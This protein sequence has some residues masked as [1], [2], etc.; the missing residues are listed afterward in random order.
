MYTKILPVVSHLVFPH[1]DP[2]YYNPEHIWQQRT[3]E[4]LRDITDLHQSIN[5]EWWMDGGTSEG[6]CVGWWGVRSGDKRG[7][8]YD[9]RDNQG[10]GMKG[11]R[12]DGG[13][14][15]REPQV[16]LRSLVVQSRAHMT[17]TNKRNPMLNHW[18]SSV[19]QLGMVDGWGGGQRG[20]VSSGGGVW[21]EKIS[22]RHCMTRVVLLIV[23]LKNVV[24]LQRTLTL[25][26]NET[27]HILISEKYPF[28]KYSGIVSIP[29][30]LT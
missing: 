6:G 11:S 30:Y 3:N 26:L 18:P 19:D 27:I 8:L 15:R 16:W 13:G 20:Y 21:G 10:G 25:T 2:L 1:Q 23:L 7:S 5:C 29:K 12:M 4:T 22:G 14:T 28:R 17:L 9:W 24:H